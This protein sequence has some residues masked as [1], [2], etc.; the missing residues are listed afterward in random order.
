MPTTHQAVHDLIV[1]VAPDRAVFEV[2]VQAGWMADL[3]RALVD[4]VRIANPS[5]AAWCWKHNKRKT[6]RDDALKLARFSAMD[7]LP[8]CTCPAGT[9]ASGG[10]NGGR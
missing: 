9:C 8:R 5:G 1:D 2:G 6:D 7:H 10:P 4:D 3:C